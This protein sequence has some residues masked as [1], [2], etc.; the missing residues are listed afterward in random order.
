MIGTVLGIASLTIT[1][2]SFSLITLPLICL[3]QKISTICALLVLVIVI[4]P[5]FLLF[6]PLSSSKILFFYLFLTKSPGLDGLAPTF[7]NFFWKTTHLDLI[8]VVIHFFRTGHM[9]RA[10]N[11]TFIALI[12][13]SK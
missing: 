5:I 10:L 8:N 2:I 11:T 4:I 9:L 3:S 12:F 1:M 7:F 6:L 13:K